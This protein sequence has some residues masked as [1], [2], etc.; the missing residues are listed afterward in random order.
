MVTHTSSSDLLHR[1]FI[2]DE[3]ASRRGAEVEIQREANIPSCGQRGRDGTLHMHAFRSLLRFQRGACWCITRARHEK[4]LDDH[5]KIRQ[6]DPQ[7][8]AQ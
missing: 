4:C 8:C 6:A 2:L 7:R 1:L 5:E 3:N